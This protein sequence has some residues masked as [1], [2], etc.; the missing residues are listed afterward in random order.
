MDWFAKGIMVV[1]SLSL[2]RKALARFLE[3]KRFAASLAL[4]WVVKKVGRAL[5]ILES[6]ISK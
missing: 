5:L 6:S 2:F 4:N 3:L 1:F